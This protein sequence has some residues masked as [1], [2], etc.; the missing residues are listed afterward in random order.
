VE[1]VAFGDVICDS[2]QLGNGGVFFA[3]P[4]L[5]VGKEVLLVDKR[6]QSDGY[7]VFE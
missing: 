7:D 6:C 4:E 3:E 5:S 1:I 2:S